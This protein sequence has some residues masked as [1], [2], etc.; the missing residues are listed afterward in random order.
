VGTTVIVKMGKAKYAF[1]TIIPLVWLV[2]V[3]STAGLTKIFAS[4]PKLGFLSHATMIEGQIAAGTLPAKFTLAAGERMIFNDRLDAA[5][6]AFFLISVVVIL[7]ASLNEWIK[8][9]GGRKTAVSSE[10]PYIRT[11]LVGEG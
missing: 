8:V 1:V 3:T 10:T 6:A 2:I 11:Q 9:I 5:V 7:T 4:D